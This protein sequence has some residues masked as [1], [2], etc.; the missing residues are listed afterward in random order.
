[1]WTRVKVPAVT[2][3]TEPSVSMNGVIS[4]ILKLLSLL[5][6]PVPL[7]VIACPATKPSSVQ[8]PDSRVMLS[9]LDPL[10]WAKVSF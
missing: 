10:P 6:A 3:P 7:I 5:A 9:K 2:D 1:M 4:L 8:L